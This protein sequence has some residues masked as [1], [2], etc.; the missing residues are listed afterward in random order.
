MV[1]HPTRRWLLTLAALAPAGATLRG[2]AAPPVAEPRLVLTGFADGREVLAPTARWRGFSDRV[3]GGVSDARFGRAT[4][5]GRECLRLAGRVTRDSGGGFIQ[6]A[7][8]LAT[9]ERDFDASAYAGIELVVHG[10]DEDYNCHV[11]TADCGWYDQS[12]RATFR[13]SPRWQA[14]RLAWADFVPNDLAVPLNPATLQR[15]AV[16]GW[17][18]DFTADI[19]VA[20]VAL[21]R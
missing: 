20:E 10:N 6:M 11:R 21:Y 17:M 4:V 8:D 15:I 12:Y 13:A 18:R 19:A 9:R 5:A 16:L 1:M 14:V 2:L 3:M 7:L